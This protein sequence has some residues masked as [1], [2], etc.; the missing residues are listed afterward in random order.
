MDPIRS[1][2]SDGPRVPTRRAAITM[3]AWTC[4]AYADPGRS[5]ASEAQDVLDDAEAAS[6][7]DEVVAILRADFPD[8]VVTFAKHPEDIRIGTFTLYLGNLRRTVAA[9]SGPARRIAILKTVAPLAGAKPRTEVKIEPFMQ[10]ATRLRLQLV[11]NEYREQVPDLTCRRFSEKLLVAYALDEPNRYQLVNRPIFD[12]WGIDQTK[13]ERVAADNLER[14]SIGVKILIAP[15]G[16]RGHFA[17]VA[18]ETGYAAARMLLPFAMN[19]VREGLKTS[20][21]VVAVPTRD[22]LMAWDP[23]SEGRPRLAG[24]VTEFMRAGPYSRSTE[25]FHFSAEGLRPL[26]VTELAAH[27]RRIGGVE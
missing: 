13:I 16:K 22:V 20:A 11:H 15:T 24:M 21:M 9:L 17:I 5:R 23:E 8:T 12:A 7:R 2:T 19:Q 6:F 18:D 14:A 1:P 10:A 4:L 25:L 26:G 27:G 3:A